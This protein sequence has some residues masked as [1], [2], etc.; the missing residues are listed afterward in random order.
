MKHKWETYFLFPF[1]NKVFE[2]GLSGDK[3]C[4]MFGISIFNLTFWIGDQTLGR[5][6]GVDAR[7]DAAVRHVSVLARTRRVVFA[8]R[9]S[10]APPSTPRNSRCTENGDRLK[11]YRFVGPDWMHATMSFRPALSSFAWS[12]RTWSTSSAKP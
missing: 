1:K 10:C 8:V 4:K 3:N 6:D 5:V 9:V 7:N 2:V 12:H 11:K